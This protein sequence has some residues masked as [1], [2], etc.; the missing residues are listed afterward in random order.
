MVDGNQRY[1]SLPLLID[2]IPWQQNVD[3]GGADK[4]SY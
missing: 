2:S 1:K 3:V 4:V